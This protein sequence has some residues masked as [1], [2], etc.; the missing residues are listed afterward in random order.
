MALCTPEELSRRLAL[1]KADFRWR[2]E[3][4]DPSPRTRSSRRR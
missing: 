3:H 4:V 1:R 2:G